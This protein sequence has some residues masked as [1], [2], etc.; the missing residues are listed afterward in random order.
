MLAAAMENEEEMSETSV[1]IE[2]EITTM[3][4]KLKTWR[5]L[6]DFRKTRK[7]GAKTS[8]IELKYTANEAPKLMSDSW[9][10]QLICQ[11]SEA[12]KEWKV[13][14]NLLRSLKEY[15]RPMEFS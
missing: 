3:E 13:L 1:R 4:K 7:T 11:L 10:C 8:E 2:K 6:Q 15:A 9:R 14:W 12:Q 5:R